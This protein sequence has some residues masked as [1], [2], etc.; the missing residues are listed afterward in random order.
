MNSKKKSLFE[1]VLDYQQ[2]PVVLVVILCIAGVVSFVTIPKQEFPEFTVLEGLVIAGFPGASSEIADER[3][4]KPLQN[5]LFSYPEVDRSKTYSVSKEGQCVVFLYIKAGV[6]PAEFW[7]KLRI[8]L[9]EFKTQLPAQVL[10]VEGISDFGDAS[11]ILLSLSSSKRSYRELEGYLSHFS[12]MVRSYG[13]VS[14]VAAFGLQKEQV[15]IYIDEQKL[16]Y[17][18]INLSLIMGEL[19]LASLAGYGAAVTEHDIKM[20]IRLP[21]EYKTEADLASQIILTTPQGDIVRL[22]DVADIKREY[23]TDSSFVQVNGKRA[24]GLSISMAAGN[25]VMQFGGK[26]DGFIRDF[27]ETLPDD[28]EITKI[29]DQPAVVGASIIH[30]FRD[31][32]IAILSVIFVIV[33]FLP[34]RI[35][36]T[37]AITIPISILISMTVLQVFGVELNTVSLAALVLV[38]GMVVDN[39]IV[40]I[41]NHVEK[42]DEGIDPREAAW[43]SARELFIPIT[44]ATFAIIAAFVPTIF[45]L[46]GMFKEFIEPAPVT[47][48]V[49]LFVSFFVAVFFVPIVNYSFIKQGVGAKSENTEKKSVLDKLQAFYNNVFLAAAFRNPKRTIFIGVAAIAAGTGLFAALPQQLF[50]KLEHSNFAV[51]FYFPEGTPLEKTARITKEVAGA[52]QEDK[53]VANVSA[54]IGESSPRFSALYAP[55]IPALNYAQLI[56]NTFTNKQ[57]EELLKEFDAKYRDIYPDAHIRWKQLDF[58]PNDAPIEIQISGNDRISI[59]TFAE[60]VKKIL[61]EEEDLIWVKDDW[62]NPLLAI[63][64]NMDNESANR[65]GITKGML[66][67]STAITHS[68]V[69]VATI[70]EGDYAKPVYLRTQYKSGGGVSDQG[71]A[72]SSP[73]DILNQYVATPAAIQPIMVRE[74]SSIEPGFT[75]GQVVRRNGRYAITVSADVAFEK[76]ASPLFARVSKKINALPAPEGVAVFYDGQHQMEMETYFPFAESLFASVVII[77]LL[78]LFQFKRLRFALLVMSTMPLAIIGGVAG[79]FIIGYPF[80]MTSF[81][82]LIGLFGIVIRNGVI[83]ISYAND[84]RTGG[85]SA[86]DAAI[87][88]GERRMRPIF[89]TASAAAVGVIP[90]ITSG[91]LLWGPLGSVICFGLIGSTILTLFVLPVAYWKFG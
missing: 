39:S 13:E 11:T 54:F 87:A 46:T 68:G 70:W 69:P 85:M 18:G 2:I 51:E 30:F 84:L 3:V 81:M 28:V 83:L 8:G 53:R 20:P 58:L 16:A 34:K 40:I 66:A 47:V 35:A 19:K 42:L 17:Y 65:L 43:T 55:Q 7:P 76:L 60:E 63:N 67:M 48:A 56:V 91:S 27:K 37:A 82:G 71:A 80:G 15:S 64:L 78:M 61:R 52:V 79:L 88:A 23:I 29:A 4:A 41:D 31:F 5:Y 73:E 10:L 72:I 57:T 33:I 12:D 24:V 25:N 1:L 26:I 50:P 6:N 86:R 74:I 22:K 77:F 32:G 38:L 59:K 89:L 90:L 49:T 45:F 36:M 75:E 44:T 62:R 21:G 9:Q 14:R